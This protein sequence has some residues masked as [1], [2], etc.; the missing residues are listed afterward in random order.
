MGHNI[1]PSYVAFRDGQRLIGQAAKDQAPRNPTNTI[2]DVKRLIGRRFNE[3]VV[4]KDKKLWPF[5]IENGP[6]NKP[7]ISVDADGKQERFHP[8]QIS[9]MVLEH[10]KKIAETYCGQGSKITNA[11]VTVPAYFNFQQK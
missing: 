2:Y 4:Q 10:M 8:E 6:D 1:T 3:D 11:V 5:N 7:V 9:A